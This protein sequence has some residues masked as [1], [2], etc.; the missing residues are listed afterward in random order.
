MPQMV[1]REKD[2]DISLAWRVLQVPSDSRGRPEC[3]WPAQSDT[4]ATH[5]ASATTVH[6]RPLVQWWLIETLKAPPIRRCPVAS[7]TRRARSR[8]MTMHRPLTTEMRGWHKPCGPHIASD[9]C[10]RLFLP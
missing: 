3:G 10:H 1:Q 5:C 8:L 7:T 9:R 2:G 4:L 6:L